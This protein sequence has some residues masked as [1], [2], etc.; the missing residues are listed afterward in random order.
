MFWQYQVNHYNLSWY[1]KS[2]TS[3]SPSSSSN[4]FSTYSD[5]DLIREPWLW[6]S[7]GNSLLPYKIIFLQV[8]LN[9]ELCK[10]DR[11]NSR[12]FYTTTISRGDGEWAWVLN[13]IPCTK[14]CCNPNSYTH[15]YY[16][17]LCFGCSWY[18]NVSRCCLRFNIS[19]N[20]RNLCIS[21]S[22][23]KICHQPC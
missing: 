16:P 6:S 23:G 14:W 20:V 3:T 18:M 1:S 19:N 22:E 2:K 4:T 8:T 13:G 11:F 9:W 12:H 15:Q 17:A 5:M 7:D 10:Y 21:W